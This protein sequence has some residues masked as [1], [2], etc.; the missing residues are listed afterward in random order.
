MVRMVTLLDIAL[1]ILPSY[2]ANSSPVVLGGG[3]SIDLGKNFGDGRRIFGPGKTIRGFVLG[4]LAGTLVGI[5]IYSNYT[6][7]FFASKEQAFLGSF[8]LAFGTLLGDA[9][10]SFIKRRANVEHGKSFLLDTFL[11]VVV[12]IVLVY[13]LIIPESL[14]PWIIAFIVGVTL[15]LHPTFNIIANKL[16]LKKV[17]H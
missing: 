10:G 7:P 14:G 6:S 4:V 15:I 11:F 13:P 1:F 5:I 12:A 2:I 17:A 3:T 8:V 16:G 9:L